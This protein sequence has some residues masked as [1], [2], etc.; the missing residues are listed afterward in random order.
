ME[1]VSV[2]S[3][4]RYLL[5]SLPLPG[6]VAESFCRVCDITSSITVDLSAS[7]MSLWSLV[8]V[9]ATEEAAHETN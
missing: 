6:V 4:S 7:V 9:V 5:L 3:P 1:V 8:L 2:L